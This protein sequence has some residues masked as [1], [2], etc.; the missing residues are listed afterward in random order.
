MDLNHV[1]IIGG[2]PAGCVLGTLLAKE[3]VPVTIIDSGKRPDLVVGESLIP[4]V[5]PHLR[6][7]GVEQQVVEIGQFKP[8][9]SIFFSDGLEWQ[10]KFSSN[11]KSAY[12]YAFN[13]PRL[14]FDAIF[15]KLAIQS[16]CEFKIGKANLVTCSEDTVTID[17]FGDASL[18]VDASGRSRTLSRQLSIPATAGKRKDVALFAH[19]TGAQLPH[20]GNIHLAVSE[21]GWSWRIPL[22]GKVSIGVVAPRD[23]VQ[24]FGLSDQE[25][26]DRLLS[27]CPFLNQYLLSDTTRLS[28]VMHYNNYQLTSDR[29]V[30]KNWVMVGDAAGFIDPVF[31]GGIYLAISAATKLAKALLN[32]Q[33]TEY[34]QQYR[35]HL[36]AWQDLADSFYDGRFFEMIRYGEILRSRGH[37]I[38]SIVE[39]VCGILS[40]VTIQSEQTLAAFNSLLSSTPF[41][42]EKLT[43]IAGH[44]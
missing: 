27:S 31:S 24:A 18:L 8:G 1:V 23:Y 25:R 39:L 21:Q 29:I 32:N 17:G 36:F 11:E 9:A 33:L 10:L 15:Q 26:F 42:S 38:Q 41:T 34:E 19:C 35:K 3:G 5:M 12:Q 13:V 22:R 20:G 28:P 37:E 4:A 14:E 30:G 44:Q 16:G 43:K 6:D 2:G 7:L 40:G